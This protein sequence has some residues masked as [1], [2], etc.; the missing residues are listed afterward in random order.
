MSP[1]ATHPTTPAASS[2]LRHANRRGVLRLLN[3]QRRCSRAEL[4][5]AMG[6]T[7]AAV[8]R[9]TRELISAGLVLEGAPLKQ[10]GS[11]GRRSSR[12]TLN[13][14]GGVVLAVNLT[15]NRLQASLNR[16]DG[17]R[18]AAHDLHSAA[19]LTPDA[20]VA[21]LVSRC[22]A[23]LDQHA[24]AAPLATGISVAV[25]NRSELH[26]GRV[27]SALLGWQ[28]VPVASAFEAAFGCPVALE[29]R[30]TGL[31]RAEINAGHV[32]PAERVL[33]VN[34]GVGIGMAF[35]SG[36]SRPSHPESTLGNLAH[37][38]HPNARIDCHC[39]RQG[40]LQQCASGVAVVRTLSLGANRSTAPL[41]HHNPHLH[42][43]IALADHGDRHAKAAFF[44]AGTHLAFGLDAAHA[45]LDP[46]QIILAGEAGRQSDFVEG[47]RAGL[48][49]AG[50][51]LDAQRLRI[52]QVT[53]DLAA[54]SIALDA[55]VFGHFPTRGAPTA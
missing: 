23:L 15:A 42:T 19:G 52:S 4:G 14:N 16:L 22:R 39:G 8:S 40:C 20:V 45:L 28:D 3:Q 49:D 38:K 46:Q 53:S 51:P 5:E 7:G 25:T 17:S 18:I 2:V 54:A 44:D 48:A 24:S 21:E 1:P 50:A 37:L 27:T 36:G 47:V 32:S 6:L 43:A 34:V 35:T 13:P 55:H 33:V 26:G 30:P 31:L 10:A 41:S 12:L 11:L 9:I 29:S